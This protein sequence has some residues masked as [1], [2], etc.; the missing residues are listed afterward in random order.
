MLHSKTVYLFAAL[1]FTAA[2]MGTQPQIISEKLLNYNHLKTAWVNNLVLAKGETAEK[3]FV[4]DKDIYVLT[5]HN[6]L[7]CLNRSNGTMRFVI[8]A[9]SKGLPVFE[10]KLYED[11]LFLIAANYLLIIDNELGVQIYKQ[12]IKF[13]VTASAT[14]NASYLYIAGMDRRLHAMDRSAKFENFAVAADNDPIVTSIVATNDYVA[15]ATDKGNIIRISPE[16]P[17][18]VWQYDTVGEISAPLVLDGQ[19]LY[20]AGRDTNLYKL[21]METG[22]L[23]WQMRTQATLSTEPRVTG[24]AVYQYAPNK[25]LYA[26]NVEDGRIMWLLENG[27]ELLAEDGEKAYVMTNDRLCS[28][29]DNK[30]G[31]KLYSINFSEVS[32]FASNTLDSAMYLLDNNGQIV[33]VE[34]VK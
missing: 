13:S 22:K 11:K 30:A 16:K 3:L 15:F 29:M 19:W 28:V 14:P 5:S 34:P 7:F 32:R 33:C 8:N 4:M 17:E 23:A 6:T 18:K 1:L 24:T 31:K 9:A 21:D 12:R 10:P 20:A 26:V 27:V 2:A 25:G